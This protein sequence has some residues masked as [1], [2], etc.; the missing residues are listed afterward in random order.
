[1]MP[2]NSI[3][4]KE[5]YLNKVAGG[6]GS[7]PS[8]PI[9]REEMFL[10]K[11]AGQDIATPSPVT[12]EEMYLSAIAESGGGGGGTSGEQAFQ[13]KNF[14]LPTSKWAIDQRIQN[15]LKEDGCVHL[16]FVVPET[17]VSNDTEVISFGAD[18]LTNWNSSTNCLCMFILYNNGALGNVN[19]LVL[20]MRGSSLNGTLWL[21]SYADQNNK[22]NLKF[23][24]DRMVNV[25]TN[26]TY[27][28]NDSSEF[29]AIQTAMNNI[30][31]YNYISVGCNQGTYRL[32]DAILDR[33]AIEPN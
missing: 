25:N 12:R 26:T 8:E 28:Y 30:E 31:N 27:F 4:R 23:Y 14:K 9:T 29:A 10:A 13:V 1:M 11:M 15:L 32:G 16:E 21:H 17:L 24:K 33:L 6:D 2:N 18:A 22:I 7:L 19:H 5:M 3:T 20:R